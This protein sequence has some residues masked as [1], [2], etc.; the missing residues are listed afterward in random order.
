MSII[1]TF[2]THLLHMIHFNNPFDESIEKLLYL[3]GEMFI[4]RM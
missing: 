1:L 2:G 3:L 4:F